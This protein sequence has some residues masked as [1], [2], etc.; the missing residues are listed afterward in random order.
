MDIHENEIKNLNI[1]KL[2]K[3]IKDGDTDITEL[4]LDLENL[5]V[6]DLLNAWAMLP[7]F[8]KPE[9]LATVVLKQTYMPYQMAVA[10]RAAGVP[11][12]V[13]KEL[14]AVDGMRIFQRVQDFLLAADS[15]Q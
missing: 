8:V 5:K 11:V 3:P 14:G 15:A 9:E 1:I 6:N 13:I 2:K 10:S 7:R 12:E 4:N